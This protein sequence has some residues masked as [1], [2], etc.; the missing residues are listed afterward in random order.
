MYSRRLGSENSFPQ[1]A[2]VRWRGDRAV[3]SGMRDDR[4]ALE[5][6][7]RQHHYLR[8]LAAALEQHP[9]LSRA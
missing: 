6:K 7:I 2:I 1:T 3:L 9:P 4:G 5:G 8:L